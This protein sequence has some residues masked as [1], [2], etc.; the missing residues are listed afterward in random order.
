MHMH[1]ATDEYKLYILYKTFLLF[2]MIFHDNIAQ[3]SHAT[4]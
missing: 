1:K 3:T 2:Q 4:T